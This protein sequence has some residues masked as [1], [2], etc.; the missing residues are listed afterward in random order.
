MATCALLSRSRSDTLRGGE[1]DDPTAARS[2]GDGWS[3]EI[4]PPSLSS[5][6]TAGAPTSGVLL[7]SS[8]LSSGPVVTGLALWALWP[9]FALDGLPCG[10]GILACGGGSLG[11]GS[12]DFLAAPLPRP[13]PGSGLGRTAFARLAASTAAVCFG[14]TGAAEE[15]DAATDV[16]TPG[17]PPATMELASVRKGLLLAPETSE[18]CMLPAGWHIRFGGGWGRGLLGPVSRV[19]KPLIC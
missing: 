11:C 2:P 13:L 1:G 7:L 4:S 19:S 3:S 5:T 9:F 17:M 8:A 12:A 14:C 15:L 10:S 6:E 16:P 18:T